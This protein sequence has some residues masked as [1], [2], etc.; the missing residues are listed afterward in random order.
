MELLKNI[1]KWI[2]K[3]ILWVL[4]F[5][6]DLLKDAI[7]NKDEIIENLETE[8]RNKVKRSVRD[9]SPEERKKAKE[10]LEA[11]ESFSRVDEI[12]M[13]ELERRG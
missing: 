9:M 11:K 13:E 10:N 1:M 3:A 8:T 12:F 4:K 6:F 7:E 2:G 5:L